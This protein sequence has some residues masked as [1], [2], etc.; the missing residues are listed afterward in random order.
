MPRSP[1]PLTVGTL[2]ARAVRGPRQDGRWYWRA[3][4]HVDGKEDS[5]WTGWATRDEVLRELAALIAGGTLDAPRNPY[6]DVR[7][8]RDLLECWIGTRK[9]RPD[10]AK[11]TLDN[12]IRKSRH[13]AAGLGDVLLERADVLTLEGYRDRRGRAGVASATLALEFNILRIAWRWGR[14]V[15]IC[16]PRALP[17]VELRVR[18]A[19]PAVTPTPEHVRAVAARLT[20]WKRVAFLLQYATGAR[21]GEIVSLTWE[22]VDLEAGT[23]RLC[24]KTGPRVIPLAADALE[25]LEALPRVKDGGVLGVATSTARI[26]LP[27]AVSEACRAAGVPEFPPYGLRRAAVDRLARAGVDIGTAAAFLGHSPTVML[28]HYRRVSLDDMRGA[29]A[30]ARLGAL[31]GGQ[32]VAFNRRGSRGE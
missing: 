4:R 18:R 1:S 16:P 17:R 19:R 15:G 20:G 12:Y 2:H 14:E 30:A 22:A 5:P 27:R 8:F 11:S 6:E 24:G 3:R 21:T 7:T 25:A 31:D 28:Q 26:G 29:V 13:L 23:V 9:G 32:V 10:L